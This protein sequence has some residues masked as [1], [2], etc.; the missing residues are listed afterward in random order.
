MYK[1]EPVV[2]WKKKAPS[3]GSSNSSWKLVLVLS[4]VMS[5]PT[6]LYLDHSL[7][8]LQNVAFHK[9]SGQENKLCIQHYKS[10]LL[11]DVFRI[12][13]PMLPIFL[14]IFHQAFPLWP[15]R[16]S[17]MLPATCNL[18]LHFCKGMLQPITENFTL[19]CNLEGFF[20]LIL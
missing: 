14:F 19:S 1:W 8:I 20:F 16:H 17:Q 13:F 4:L 5:M 6:S 2:I 15:I 7:G 12:V 9:K 11:V 18:Q 10:N 3:W